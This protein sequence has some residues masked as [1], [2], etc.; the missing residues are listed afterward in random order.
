MSWEG[1]KES[2]LAPG[3]VKVGAQGR[4]GHGQP[5]L[6]MCLAYS[7]T[8]SFRFSWFGLMYTGCRAQGPWK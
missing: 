6:C 5:G 3:K 1:C 4:A 8:L 7:V 2:S